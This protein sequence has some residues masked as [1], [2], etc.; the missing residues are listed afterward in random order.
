[1]NNILIG[2]SGGPTAVINASL[3][4]A[5]KESLED[6]RVDKV[7][8]MINGIEGFLE[9]KVLDFNEYTGQVDIEMLKTTP[10]SFLGS[11]RYK[12]P[13]GYDEEVYEKLFDRFEEMDI[14]EVVYIGG[15]DSMDTVAKLSG[16]AEKKTSKVRF[17]GVPKTI[18]NDLVCTD[19]TPGFGSAAKYVA[20]AVREVSLDAGVYTKPTVTIVELMGR[21][22][23][24]ITAASMLARTE[25]E[26]NPMLIYLPE[27][28]FD[29]EEFI[30]DVRGALKEKDSVVVCI[31]EG[32]ADKE[33]RLICEYGREADRDGFGHK[34]LTG[35]GKVL[36]ELVKREIGCKS[37]SIELNLPQRCSAVLASATDIEE[38]AEAGRYGA[39]AAIEGN[40][41]KMAAFE[42][43]EGEEYEIELKLVE[44]EE[45]CNREKKFPKEWI[46]GGGRDISEEFRGY[47]LPLIQGES[48]VRF[49]KGLPVYMRS[50]YSEQG[51]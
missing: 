37:R 15:N 7:Y 47:V 34:M 29:P 35:S 38:A 18:D 25:H 21:H 36:E 14:K 22:A 51:R 26:R 2:Q 33:G 42:R 5:V 44:V 39:E 46:T 45:V 48:R 12:L 27:S 20:T 4:G 11:C 16:Y 24:W 9:G 28:S 41:G 19:H 6:S 3:Y 40:T 1:M 43:K 30:E 10:A 31:S 50:A 17:I 49:E 23:G 13:Q 8:G 32:I